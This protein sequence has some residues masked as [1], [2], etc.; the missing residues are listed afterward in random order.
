MWKGKRIYKVNGQIIEPYET[1]VVFDGCVVDNFIP[2]TE[3][4]NTV[5]P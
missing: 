5:S 3:L 4:S 1:D 2:R